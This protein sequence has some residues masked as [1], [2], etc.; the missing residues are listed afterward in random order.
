MPNLGESN[1]FGCY[2]YEHHKYIKLSKKHHYAL[3]NTNIPSV[4]LHSVM[5]QV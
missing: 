5:L 4:V 3:I 1:I 2:I